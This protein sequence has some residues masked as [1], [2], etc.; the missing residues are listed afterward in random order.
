MTVTQP[1]KCHFWIEQIENN[2]GNFSLTENT[3]LGYNQWPPLPS[4][5]TSLSLNYMPS[6]LFSSSWPQLSPV[7]GCPEG[8]VQE[9]GSGGT[10][11]CLTW[12]LEHCAVKMGSSD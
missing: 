3:S 2:E 1:R 11:S 9:E 6:S 7:L 10:G 12:F 8:Q 4:R 5:V